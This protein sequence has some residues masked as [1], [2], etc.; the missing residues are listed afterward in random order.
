MKTFLNSI[1][2]NTIKQAAIKTAQNERGAALI[3][4]ALI[5]A[6]IVGVV[7][8]AFTSDGG[9]VIGEAITG[10]LD[11]VAGAINGQTGG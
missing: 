5:T 3:E 9:G 2:F 7:S 11:S 6:A 1:K 10:L 4:Y 8:F